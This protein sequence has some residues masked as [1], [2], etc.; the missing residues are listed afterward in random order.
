[1]GQGSICM[2]HRIGYISKCPSCEYEDNSVCNKCG[3]EKAFI[4]ALE[5]ELSGGQWVCISDEC[6]EDIQNNLIRKAADS[7]RGNG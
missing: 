4:S 6:I 5:G 2:R 7:L 3:E 1:M